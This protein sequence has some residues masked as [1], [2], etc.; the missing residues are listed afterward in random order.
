[1]SGPD[2]GLNS[3]GS[4]L[5]PLLCPCPVIGNAIVWPSPVRGF[6]EST[7]PGGGGGGSCDEHLLSV[8][9]AKPLTGTLH[10]LCTVCG[11]SQMVFSESV[12]MGVGGRAHAGSSGH[13]AEAAPER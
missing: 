11:G 9:G 3:Q 2:L 1:M 8:R 13:S 12:M 6:P 5:P 7:E 10:L 4:E